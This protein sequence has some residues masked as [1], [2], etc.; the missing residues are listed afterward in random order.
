VVDKLLIVEDFGPLPE[1]KSSGKRDDENEPPRPEVSE[2]M[3][4]PLKVIYNVAC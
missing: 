4:R 2:E 1:M 3:L